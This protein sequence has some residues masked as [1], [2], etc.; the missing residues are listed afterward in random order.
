[1][2]RIHFVT[3]TV[4]DPKC[5]SLIG[6]NAKPNSNNPI[7]QFGTGLKYA[8]AIC[9]RKNWKLQIN[10]VKN[11]I[12]QKYD[13]N[14]CEEPFRDE[15]V[16]VVYCNDLP[17]PY[18]THLGKH[19]DDWTVIRELLS[20]TMDENGK[21]IIEQD[22]KTPELKDNQTCITVESEQLYEIAKDINNYFL[23]KNHNVIAK[24]QHFELLPE[25][26]AGK[27]FLKGILVGEIKD[28]KFG[29]NVTDKATLSE[30]R[31]LSDVWSCC[32][33]I[34]TSVTKCENPED[35]EEFLL[36]Q[37]QEKLFY[38][39][40][41]GWGEKFSSFI[42]ELASK[43]P[44]LINSSIFSE[45]KRSRNLEY[46]KLELSKTEEKMLNIAVK[47]I[48]EGGFKTDFPI[49]KI[50]SSDNNC[51]AFV[52][53]GEIFVTRDLFAF[54][55]DKLTA[56]LIEEM[57]HCIGYS[58]ESREYEHYLCCQLARLLWIGDLE[59]MKVETC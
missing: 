14:I 46:K 26:H 24:N 16:E 36:S 43:S 53:K 48:S 21:M 37:G 19:W 7:G 58:D 22:K 39:T 59:S 5:W 50:E 13:F 38:C 35:F 3:E 30:D 25:K 34:Y 56:V 11:N 9:M 18:T 47:R 6:V 23:E 17:L 27:V 4:I 42:K 57:S 51:P 32:Y 15:Q 1:M 49:F 40:T 41:T 12:A 33:D 31:K 10:S 52:V 29:Y 8:I 2:K 55:M 45:L 44:T 20:N 54:G 28:A